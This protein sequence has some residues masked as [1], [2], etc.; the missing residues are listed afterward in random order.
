MWKAVDCQQRNS[1]AIEY[2]IVLNLTT[3]KSYISVNDFLYSGL[4]SVAAVNH[5][6]IGPF[7]D[8]VGISSNFYL[9]Y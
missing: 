5:I 2:M 1:K 9:K 7:S 4:F 8:A 3:N 6:G